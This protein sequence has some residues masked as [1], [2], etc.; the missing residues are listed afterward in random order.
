MPTGLSSDS[1]ASGRVPTIVEH[2]LRRTILG[3]AGLLGL[4]NEPMDAVARASLG[5]P[6][7]I[8][9]QLTCHC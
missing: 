6:W 8:Q 5:G 4:L 9:V 3:I 2:I 1:L 7:I